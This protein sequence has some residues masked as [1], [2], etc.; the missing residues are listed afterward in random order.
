MSLFLNNT[1]DLA[2]ITFS[3]KDIF[4]DSSKGNR[5]SIYGV[6]HLLLYLLILRDIQ[7]GVI[8]EDQIITFSRGAS[9]EKNA[10]RS[11][12]GDIGEKRLL[13]DVFNQSVSLNAPDCLRALCQLYGGERETRKRLR[14]LAVEL[15]V[16]LKSQKKPYRKKG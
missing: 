14:A 9:I 1:L 15:N 11:T 12:K 16:S 4:S 3:R 8:N 2:E 13:R 10:K 5:Q 7:K 6:N